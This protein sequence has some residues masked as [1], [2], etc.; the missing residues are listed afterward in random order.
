MLEPTASITPVE[1]DIVY[2]ILL[3]RKIELKKLKHTFATIALKI[4][5]HFK[6]NF[7][8]RDLR[9]ISR[10]FDLNHHIISTI[11]STKNVSLQ[12]PKRTKIKRRSEFW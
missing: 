10:K 4:G 3:L 9:P 7:R 6:G 5:N 11:Y 1:Y 12:F 8:F 2:C